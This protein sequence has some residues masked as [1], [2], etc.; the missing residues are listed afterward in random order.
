MGDI[1][2]ALV[3]VPLT[4][5][6]SEQ[7]VPHRNPPV[8][9]Y[10]SRAALGGA[11]VALWVW[12][13]ER[14]AGGF[15]MFED[16]MKRLL[17]KR[18]VATG[19]ALL[20]TSVNG[21][22]SVAVGLVGMGNGGGSGGE[23]G[24]N[25]GTSTPYGH[26]GSRSGLRSMVFVEGDEDDELERE[27]NGRLGLGLGNSVLGN[28]HNFPRVIGSG[29]GGIYCS[30]QM[31]SFFSTSLPRTTHTYHEMFRNVFFNLLITLFHFEK[32]VE[33]ESIPFLS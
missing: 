30:L 14:G 18:W 25:S 11:Y 17:E 20:R 4:Q 1:F 6:D 7:V 32:K 12:S 28:S 23:S 13:R 24:A 21:T 9:G 19:G 26:P 22:S 8:Q 5:F 3:F 2:N 16:E 10:T 29:G 27:R 31:S 33:I 15:G